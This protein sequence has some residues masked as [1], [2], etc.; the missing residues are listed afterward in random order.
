MKA[1]NIEKNF[2]QDMRLRMC[3]V[4]LSGFIRVPWLKIRK[5]FT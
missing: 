2:N 3:S 1:K 5:V 4:I